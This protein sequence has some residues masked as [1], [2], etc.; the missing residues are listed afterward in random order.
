MAAN[1]VFRLSGGSSN[2]DPLLS[3]GGIMSSQVVGTNLFDNVSSAE[4]LAGDT[5]YR[6]FDIYNSGDATANSVSFYIDPTG[7][8]VTVSTGKDADNE[9][10]L[11]GADLETVAGEGTAPVSPVITFANNIAAAP[12]SLDS[13]E[14]GK[15]TRIWIKRVVD[16]AE[17]NK[18]G[19]G[20]T[21]Y[22]D[23]A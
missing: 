2:S 13:I 12:L 20:V 19:D 6:A 18:S 5:E 7:V 9:N 21:L 1:L 22:V 14:A 3:L 8:A 16:P 4:A 11:S 15:A 17:G 10:H 23:F